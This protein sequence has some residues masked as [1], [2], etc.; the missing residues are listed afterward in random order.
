LESS[1]F[2]QSHPTSA[3]RVQSDINGG[4]SIAPAGIAK[5]RQDGLGLQQP[6]MHFVQRKKSWTVSVPVTSARIS[7]GVDLASAVFCHIRSDRSMSVNSSA[8]SIRRSASAAAGWA[9]RNSCNM[10]RRSRRVCNCARR[11]SILRRATSSTTGVV[12]VR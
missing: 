2:L 4:A 6:A 3:Q 5:Q 8:R 9:R 1:A 7:L 12:P 11:P 10:A